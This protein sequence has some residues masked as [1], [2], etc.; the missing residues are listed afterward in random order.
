M[1]N[2]RTTSK[3]LN[4]S[5]GQQALQRRLLAL[6]QPSTNMSPEMNGYLTISLE[7]LRHLRDTVFS[8]KKS[9]CVVEAGAQYS[10]KAMLNLATLA[11][12]VVQWLVAEQNTFPL[13]LSWGR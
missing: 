4:S 13:H 7:A 10:K 6:D 3:V 11:L 2:P 12:G 1:R 5:Y 8:S 9:C